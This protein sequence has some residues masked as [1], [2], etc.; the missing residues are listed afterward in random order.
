MKEV[1]TYIKIRNG[2]LLIEK[3]DQ[4]AKAISSLPDGLYT[5]EVKKVYDK[6]T[7]RQNKYYWGVVLPAFVKG[8]RETTGESISP[9]VAHDTLKSQFCFT[10]F[11]NPDTGEVV[12][13]VD[14]TT[15]KKTVEFSEYVEHCR[16]FISE[17]FHYETPDPL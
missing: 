16:R 4:F 17:W 10:D 5:F 13:V 12:K 9:D 6:R 2:K 14:S 1:N 15:Q 3:S 8:Y 7:N 11:V